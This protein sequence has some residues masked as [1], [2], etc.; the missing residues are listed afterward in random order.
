MVLATG[1]SLVKKVIAQ[2]TVGDQYER[3]SSL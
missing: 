2:M 1:M 3:D